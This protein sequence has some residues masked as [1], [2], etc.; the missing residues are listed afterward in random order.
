MLSSVIL[1]FSILRGNPEPLIFRDLVPRMIASSQFGGNSLVSPL[2]AS[3][4]DFSSVYGVCSTATLEIISDMHSLTRNYLTRWGYASSLDPALHAQVASC[5]AQSQQAYAR[6]LQRPSTLN[7]T[8][9]NWVYESCRLA[10]LIYCRSILHGSSLA[11][12]AAAMYVNADHE[13]TNVTL[14]SALHAAVMQT[15]TRNCWG[16]MRGVFL[17]VSLIGGAAAWPRPRFD[18]TGDYAEEL[19]PSEVWVR[20]YFSLLSI[21]AAVSVPFYQAGTTIEALRTMHQVRQWM[22]LNH[23]G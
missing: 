16:E 6:L 13:V 23:G 14:L 3:H 2:Y 15:D 12:S 19:S 8:F 7:D 4:G 18:A 20:K 10:A 21:K 22:D 17:W 11:N 1:C 9:L 5:D